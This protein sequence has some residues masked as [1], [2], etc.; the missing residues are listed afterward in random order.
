V[1]ESTRTSLMTDADVLAMA[2]AV[3]ATTSAVH[4]LDTILHST[5]FRS[6]FYNRSI[7]ISAKKCVWR[8]KPTVKCHSGH[9]C[10]LEFVA[11]ASESK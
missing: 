6:H 10:V 4:N 8:E 5:T 11:A 1:V 2:V 7:L 3:Q 9:E